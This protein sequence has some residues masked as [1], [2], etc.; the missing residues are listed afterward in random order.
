MSLLSAA[1]SVLGSLLVPG[2]LAASSVTIAPKIGIRNIYSLSTLTKRLRE[3]SESGGTHPLSALCVALAGTLGVG[4]ITG[5]AS[6]LMAGGPGALF[7]MWIG[8]L[9]VLPVKYAEVKLAVLHRRRDRSG[10][11]GGAMYYLSDGLAGPMPQRAAGVTGRIFAFLCMLNSLLTGNIVQANAAACVTDRRLLC[12]ALLG[13]LVLVS[14]LFGTRKIER[15][16]SLIIP[17]LAV[18]YVSACLAVILPNMRLLPW[19]F[20]TVVLSALSP[21]AAIGAAMG[22]SVRQAVRFG[23]MRGIFSNEA[24]CG[25]SPTAHASADTRSPDHQ[26]SLGVAEVVF[27]TLILCTL[28]ALTL[29]VADIRWGV[30]PW[31]ESADAAGVTMDAFARGAGETVASL[32]RLSVLLFAYS[33][34][35]AQFYYGMTAVRYLTKKKTAAVLYGLASSVSPVIGAVIP[36]GMMWGCADLLLGSMTLLNC[37]ALI[38]LSSRVGW[39][40]SPR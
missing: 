1:A 40:G 12:G 19:I 39:A 34:I 37:S 22:F 7:W 29:L 33:S 31:H 30:L 2:I 26:A 28:T 27:D 6:A 21:R 38:L 11:Y 5:V 24:G 18:F 10:Y 25:T 15:I 3:G 23:I 35:I 14:I 9:L 16:A 13:V 32:V 36:S 20:R 4:N 17:P 8:A